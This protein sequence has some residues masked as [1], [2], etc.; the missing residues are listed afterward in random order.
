MKKLLLFFFFLFSY[1]FLCTACRSSRES[2]QV[3]TQ[4][5]AINDEQRTSQISILAM[6]DSVTYFVQQQTKTL[7][8]QIRDSTR[9]LQAVT[10]K[11]PTHT[12]SLTL[13]TVILA[14]FLL[15]LLLFFII[16]KL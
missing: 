14:L 12:K 6:M 2:L 15:L 11:Q 10:E 3:H 9:Q 4:T 5:T 16:K 13:I 1:L 7:T 8:H